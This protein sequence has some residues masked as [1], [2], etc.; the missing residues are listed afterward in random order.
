MGWLG[1]AEM[2]VFLGRGLPQ[3]KPTMECSG[4]KYHEMEHS[5]IQDLDV[6]E[7]SHLLQEMVIHLLAEYNLRLETFR[8]KLHP[9][10]GHCKMKLA[11]ISLMTSK[12]RNIG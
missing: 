5:H 10:R 12:E 7:R 1:L 6:D 9:L 3:Q 2:G 4:H 11:A 8:L